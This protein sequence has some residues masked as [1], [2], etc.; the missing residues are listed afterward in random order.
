MWNLSL[1]LK[2][3][4][5]VGTGGKTEAS[6]SGLQ[7]RPQPLGP[8]KWQPLCLPEPGG[9]VLSRHSRPHSCG[10]SSHCDASQRRKSA[11]DESGFFRSKFYETFGKKHDFSSESPKLPS[12]PMFP[13]KRTPRVR[14]AQLFFPGKA[15]SPRVSACVFALALVT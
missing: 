11:T 5:P 7:P 6:G 15:A 8:S 9:P 3:R 4:R 14:E 13:S 1:D 10:S 12:P 2:G